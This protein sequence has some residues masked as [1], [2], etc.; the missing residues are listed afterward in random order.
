MNFAAANHLHEEL[1]HVYEKDWQ[2]YEREY[3]RQLRRLVAR[4]QAAAGLTQLEPEPAPESEGSLRQQRHHCM[5]AAAGGAALA[6]TRSQVERQRTAAARQA[7][8]EAEAAAA[9]AGQELARTRPQLTREAAAAASQLATP[10][11]LGALLAARRAADP[12]AADPR[13]DRPA[14]MRGLLQQLRAAVLQKAGAALAGAA[15]GDDAA[16]AADLVAPETARAVGKRCKELLRDW[17]AAETKFIG[18]GRVGLERPLPGTADPALSSNSQGTFCVCEKVHGANFVI[19]IRRGSA[20]LRC[21]KRTGWL[22]PGEDFFGHSGP[23]T[24]SRAA[25][26]AVAAA[27]LAPRPTARRA[28]LFGELCGGSYP[29]PAAGTTDDA[30]AEVGCGGGSEASSSVTGGAVLSAVQV[31]IW[32]S[33]RVEL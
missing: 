12:T 19:S 16:A 29:Q 10:E 25:L 30:V 27:L 1:Q 14:E 32:Y 11:A 33:R 18:Y 4:L 26:L 9:A 3:G 21:G 8:S 2:H 22:Q 5:P 31:G 23:V 15:A 24:R 17:A 6:R 28:V 20:Q 13:A 7:D